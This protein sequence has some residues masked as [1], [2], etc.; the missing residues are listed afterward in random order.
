[1]LILPRGSQK[2]GQGAT[3]NWAHPF[4]RGLTLCLPFFEGQWQANTAGNATLHAIWGAVA[5]STVITQGVK[6]IWDSNVEGN[7]L[8]IQDTGSLNFS[9]VLPANGGTIAIVRRKRDT[10]LRN[11]CLV[12]DGNT[13]SSGVQ[14]L[15]PFSDGNIYWRFGG[16]GNQ[17]VVAQSW[18]TQIDRMVFTAGFNG[19]AIW[20]NG[21]K[22]ASSATAVT[23]TPTTSMS[24]NGGGVTGDIQDLNFAWFVNYP[25]SDALCQW[26]SAEPYA[27]LTPPSTRFSLL[28]G[29]A[30]AAAGSPWLHYAQ[31]RG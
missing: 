27:A 26:W 22:I 2:P 15:C 21:R 8:A 25:W 18:N 5:R 16:A 19:T 3:V 4:A 1:M 31:L 13:S 10:T 7:A 30:A 17:L 14:L 23:S 29:E 12:G 24:I 9:Y 20:R 6:A 11:G 28:L